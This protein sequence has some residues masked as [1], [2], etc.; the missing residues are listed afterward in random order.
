M[1]IFLDL[2][3]VYERQLMIVKTWERISQPLVMTKAR[4]SDHYIKTLR[5]FDNELQQQSSVLV[6]QVFLDSESSKSNPSYDSATIHNEKWIYFF[7]RI[8]KFGDDSDLQLFRKNLLQS[9]I[10]V[11]YEKGSYC[12]HECGTTFDKRSKLH[13]MFSEQFGNSKNKY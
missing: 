7:K 2:I 12:I 1:R 8:H 11:E 6:E 10:E 5:I 3:F 4:E 9:N 13:A